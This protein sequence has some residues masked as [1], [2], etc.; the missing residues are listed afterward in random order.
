MNELPGHDSDI[1]AKRREHILE[2]ARAAGSVSVE[3][4]AER[5][6]VTPQTIRKD[7]NVLAER[8]LLSRVHGGALVTSGVSN[9]AYDA[10]R[11]VAS[12]AKSGIGSAAAALVPDGASLFIN[13]GTTVEAV[14]ANLSHHRDL[15]I[16]S[17]NLN[18]IDMLSGHPS[19]QLVCVGGSV[20]TADRAVVGALAMR[21]IDNFKVDYAIIG[22]SALD[23]DGSLLDFDIDEVE[24]AQRIIS[25]ARKVILVADNT[26]VGRS[27]P[28]RICGMDEIDFLVCDRIEDA[29]LRA[30]IARGGVELI[31]T[32][33]AH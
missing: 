23:S 14:A 7:L 17:N 28:V 29:E 30:A 22:V 27:A 3:Y 20:R 18:V 32:G 16:I 5:L 25:N 24:V 6:E 1:V 8:S 21:F 13:V 19:A 10:R 2:L 15:V 31:E 11:R 4:L 33:G 9:L 12:E 26:K